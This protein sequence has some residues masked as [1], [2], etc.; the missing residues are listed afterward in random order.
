MEVAL[1]A[2]VLALTL[3]GMIQVIQSGSEMLDVSRKQ[4]IA[5]QILHDEID[6]LRLQSWSYVS[7]TIPSTLTTIPG[8]SPLAISTVFGSVGG[9]FT[10]KYQS[11]QVNDIAGAA[12]QMYQVTF[13]VTW[14]GITGHTYSR[15]GTTLVSKNGLS[16]AF[17][18]S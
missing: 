14:T 17:Q 5:A 15:M 3:T 2:T 8:S 11:T 7:G 4:T 6:Q 12:I 1:A 16:V 13:K 9:N 18:R 10:C